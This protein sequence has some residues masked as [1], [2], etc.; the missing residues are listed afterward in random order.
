MAIPLSNRRRWQFA[1]S[2]AFLACVYILL[3]GKEFAA[4]VFASRAELPL[5]ERAVRL[6]P[7]NADYRHRLGRYFAF[8]AANPQSAIES[9]RT[10]V[11]LNPHD[12][13]YWF[14]LAAAY[15]VTG[16]NSGQRAAL[17]RALQA[18]PTAPDVAW[19]AANFFLIDGDI[20]RALREF[21][22][23]I[24]NDTSLWMP[25]CVRAG[26]CVLTQTLCSATWCR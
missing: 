10:A 12:A 22:V 1:F 9:L 16:D 13:R 15:Q 18:E 5:L 3:A 14:D 25:L 11:T 17:D 4:S 7:G 8:V 19:E 6:S 20:D 21:H 23:V 2:V 24:E 26:A